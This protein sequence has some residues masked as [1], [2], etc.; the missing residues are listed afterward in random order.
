[1]TEVVIPDSVISIGDNAFE[2]CSS[3]TGIVI[4]DS[5][6]SIGHAA[7]WCCS[8]L[9]SIVIPDSVTS[10][11]S[12]A[13]SGCSSLTEITV[14]EKNANYKDIDG[15]LYSKDGKALVQYAEG[16]NE[17]TFSIPDSVTSIGDGAFEYCSSLTSIVIPDS[18][19]SIGNYA[20]FDCSSLSEIVI[21][22]SVTSVGNNAFSSCD[23]LTNVY[24]KGSVAE[25]L[26]ITIEFGNEDLTEE[27]IYYYSEQAPTEEGNFWYY[28][29]NGDIAVWG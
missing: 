29:E 4:P 15:N 16:K 20:F 6:T 28:D 11:G 7:F 14:S 5:V 8:S 3:L 10:I 25:W 27:T 24:Y 1:M 21:P 23:S 13:F 22:E 18:V 12:S 17:T 26:Q 2:H 9:T 19:T